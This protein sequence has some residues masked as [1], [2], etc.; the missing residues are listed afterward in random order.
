MSTENK[1][2]FVSFN[3]QH[4]KEL[5]KSIIKYVEKKSQKENVIFAIQELPRKQIIK[6]IN[7]PNTVQFIKRNELAFVFPKRINI[8][9]S[10]FNSLDCVLST[11]QE[12]A[13]YITI[14][15][16][17]E[18]LQIANIHATS[19][20]QEESCQTANKVLFQNIEYILG[21]NKKRIY[22][23]D[24]NTNPYEDN[25]VSN[26]IICSSR[27]KDDPRT[28]VNF[29]NPG[30]RYLREKRGIK[31][32]YCNCKFFPRWQIL[33]HIL[34]SKELCKKKIFSFNILKTF[35]DI[36]IDLDEFEK[37]NSSTKTELSDHLPISLTM[38]I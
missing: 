12:N 33:D 31:G 23:G 4:K 24:F 37:R 16:N 9:Q 10:K 25:L 21:K 17:K 26:K 32:T 27:E 34:V 15:L 29:Y 14:P 7:L 5:F 30:W 19:K 13:M 18:E 2:T 8:I 35:S 3:I 28:S 22:L 11:I 36:K 20:I 38:E 6:K 1:F